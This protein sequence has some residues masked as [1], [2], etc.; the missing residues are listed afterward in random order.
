MA[1]RA[2]CPWCVAC[3]LR[4]LPLNTSLLTAPRPYAA[5]QG[6]CLEGAAELIVKQWKEVKKA[7]VYYIDNKKKAAYWPDA[8]DA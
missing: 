2:C 8:E 1:W 4:S 6:D 3:R 5:L 7:D